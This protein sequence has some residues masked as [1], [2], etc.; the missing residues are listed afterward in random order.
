MMSDRQVV[1]MSL[2][3]HAAFIIA[4]RHCA[5]K[6]YVMTPVTFTGWPPSWIGV[7]RA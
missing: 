2:I 1:F 3:H 6:L 7:K 4:F 5:T